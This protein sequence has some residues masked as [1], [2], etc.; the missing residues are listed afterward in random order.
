MELTFRDTALGIVAQTPVFLV[1]L[2]AAGPFEVNAEAPR[3]ELHTD[4]GFSRTNR[5]ACARA[6]V[7][8][9]A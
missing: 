1:C 5:P 8:K 7:P 2:E 3:L 9:D 4:E 6:D